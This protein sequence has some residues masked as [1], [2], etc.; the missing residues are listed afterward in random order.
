MLDEIRIQI[1][2]KRYCMLMDGDSILPLCL[3]P[4][5]DCD[6][7]MLSDEVEYGHKAPV[8]LDCFNQK[9]YFEWDLTVKRVSFSFMSQ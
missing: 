2:E 4:C 7:I 8:L 5:F 6:D 3:V 9:Y 1:N